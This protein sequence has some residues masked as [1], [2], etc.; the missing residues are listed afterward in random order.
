M[1]QLS[2]NGWVRRYLSGVGRW[3]ITDGFPVVIHDGR[4][5][6]L[7]SE[8][9]EDRPADVSTNLHLRLWLRA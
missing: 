6:W 2:F 5:A 3:R 4:G 7:W 8:L 1:T 9:P